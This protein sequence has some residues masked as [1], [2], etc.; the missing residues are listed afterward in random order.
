MYKFSSIVAEMA[1]KLWRYVNECNEVILHRGF[2]NSRIGSDL[3]EDSEDKVVGVGGDSGHIYFQCG[4]LGHSFDDRTWMPTCCL[5]N[6]LYKALKYHTI[7]SAEPRCTLEWGFS[8]R[9]DAPRIH[10]L[11]NKIENLSDHGP[12]GILIAVEVNGTTRHRYAG[13]YEVKINFTD[14]EHMDM[15]H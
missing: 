11:R 4:E 1:S 3:N 6:E 14:E 13:H 9:M 10:V 7:A 2:F 12:D 15:F 5:A 8:A